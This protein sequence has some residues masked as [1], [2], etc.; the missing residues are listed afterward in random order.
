MTSPDRVID[1]HTTPLSSSTKKKSCLTFPPYLF[2]LTVRTRISLKKSQRSC[3]LNTETINGRH[4][5]ILQYENDVVKK[6]TSAK[7]HCAT[8]VSLS[9]KWVYSHKKKNGRSA[10]YW[11]VRTGSEM[12]A[13]AFEVPLH[14]H[15]FLC[16]KCL[17]YL[18][19]V[20]KNKCQVKGDTHR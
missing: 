14:F 16:N 6:A 13:L 11:L 5:I 2:S 10:S 1:G 9:S 7:V 20:K 8:V 15:A 12:S 17:A 19:E 4:S 3:E 18:F